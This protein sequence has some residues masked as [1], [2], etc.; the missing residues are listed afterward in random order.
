[1]RENILIHSYHKS[2]YLGIGYKVEFCEIEVKGLNGNL[3]EGHWQLHIVLIF[4]KWCGYDLLL[5]DVDEI[6]DADLEDGKEEDRNEK[7][8]DVTSADDEVEISDSE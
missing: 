7:E 5:I 4:Q 2:N 8:I 3:S 6:M 1:M